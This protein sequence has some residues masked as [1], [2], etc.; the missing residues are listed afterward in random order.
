LNTKSRFN[1]I[2]RLIE[3]FYPF[4][5]GGYLGSYFIGYLSSRKKIKLR[6]ERNFKISCN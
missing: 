4:F 3:S 2:H 1:F 6:K 5:F